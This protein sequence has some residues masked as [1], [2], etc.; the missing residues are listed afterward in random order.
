LDL[1]GTEPQILPCEE[2]SLPQ[3]DCTVTFANHQIPEILAGDINPVEMV[4]EGTLQIIG[5]AELAEI[6]ALLD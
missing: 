5:D 3:A 6:L 4:M 1:T 2:S